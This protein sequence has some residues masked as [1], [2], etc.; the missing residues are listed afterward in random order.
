MTQTAIEQIRYDMKEALMLAGTRNVCNGSD[1]G[2]S[3]TYSTVK[4]LEWDVRQ[5]PEHH[6]IVGVPTIKLAEDMARDYNLPV[7]YGKEKA[8]TRDPD[9]PVE[10]STEQCYLT[11]CSKCGNKEVCPY[12]D[13]AFNAPI[14]VTA[15][16]SIPTLPIHIGRY[17][18]VD[19]FFEV[20]GW[21][22][23]VFEEDPM[24]YWYGELDITEFIANRIIGID[25]KI[26]QAVWTNL[27]YTFYHNVTIIVNRIKPTEHLSHYHLQHFIKTYHGLEVFHYVTKEGENRYTLIGSREHM[28]PYWINQVIYNDATFIPS[29]RNVMFGNKM[30][31]KDISIHNELKNPICR[32]GYRWGRTTQENHTEE[33]LSLLEYFNTINKKIL[34]VTKQTIEE[35]ISEIPNVDVVHYGNSRGFNS[36]FKAYDLVIVYGAFYWD[37]SSI[38]KYTRLGMNESIIHEIEI[39]EIIQAVNRFRPALQPNIPI[40]LMTQEIEY[41]CDM[42]LMPKVLEYWVRHPLTNAKSIKINQ[43][44]S[45]RKLLFHYKRFTAWL[46]KHLFH[47]PTEE[48]R[49]IDFLKEG[50]TVKEITQLTGYSRSNIYKIK[51]GVIPQ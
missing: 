19:R 5:N 51:K 40:L 36:N 48:E 30:H 46:Q 35:T 29:Q 14:I 41:K 12:W 13:Q 44:S 37:P 47:E 27:T 42:V 24:R 25:D 32:L 4:R 38:A 21:Y 1:P 7:I 17:N 6:W 33:L 39:G 20:D 15:Y 31:W 26:E 11:N 43:K 9:S 22:G 16:E 45:Q 2:Y 28:K 23:L 34:V 49:V 50:K 8:I 10:F 3:K 18:H